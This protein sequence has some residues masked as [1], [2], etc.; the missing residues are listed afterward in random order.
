MNIINSLSLLFQ[1]L[2][3]EN[4]LLKNELT[5]GSKLNLLPKVNSLY[6]ISKTLHIL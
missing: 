4:P 1:K 5:F 6:S 3:E 2:K